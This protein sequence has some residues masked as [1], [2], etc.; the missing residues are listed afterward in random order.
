V[1]VAVL[2]AA[3]L[4]GTHTVAALRGAG[5]DARPLLRAECDITKLAT[6]EKQLAGATAVINCAAF[7]NVDAAETDDHAHEVNGLGAENV[8]LAARRLGLFSLHLSTDFVFD[9]AQAEPYHEEASARPISRY[10]A[11]KLDGEQRFQRAGGHALVRVQGLYGRGGR[12]FASRLV[13][14]LRAKHPLRIDGER[15]VQPTWAALAAR[16]LVTLVERREEGLFHVS[17][18]GET[19]WAGFARAVCERLDLAP[20][21]T[22]VSSTDLATPAARPP[23]CL[24]AHRRLQLRGLPTLPSWQ[25]GL[26]QYLAEAS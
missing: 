8:A 12:N 16:A 9:G 17:S 22:V 2:G 6:V 18:A 25:D 19:T 3:G 15:R 1:T 23:N 11:S 7:T 4:L 13:E 26:Q 14:L 20:E 5:I 10:G 24:F 21:F